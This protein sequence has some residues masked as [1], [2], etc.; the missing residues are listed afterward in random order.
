MHLSNRR[1]AVLLA[2]LLAALC[3]GGL[4]AHYT[5]PVEVKPQVMMVDWGTCPDGTEVWNQ[6]E[7]GSWIRYDAVITGHREQR[8][9]SFPVKDRDGEVLYQKV[10]RSHR[11]VEVQSGGRIL[12]RLADGRNREDCGIGR[13]YYLDC[14]HLS[15]P[16]TGAS[17]G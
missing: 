15:L 7:G 8:G 16:S 4:L 13:S 10:I 2:C 12:V 6:V 14:L 3:G 17:S 11:Y 5:T 1:L 9:C